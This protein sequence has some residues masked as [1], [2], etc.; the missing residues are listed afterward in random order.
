M[1]EDFPSMV[2]VDC[3]QDSSHFAEHLEKK[4]DPAELPNGL[5][6]YI[7]RPTVGVLVIG[8]LIRAVQEASVW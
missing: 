1:P 7:I 4:K 5:L 8:Q 2:I 3:E 6:D